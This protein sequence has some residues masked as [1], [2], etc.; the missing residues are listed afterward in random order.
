MLSLS[1][2]FALHWSSPAHLSGF[3]TSTSVGRGIGRWY[4]QGVDKLVFPEEDAWKV[5]IQ[6]SGGTAT[7]P[8]LGGQASWRLFLGLCQQHAFHNRNHRE[9]TCPGKKDAMECFC[10][11]I[12][13]ACQGDQRRRYHRSHQ[14]G[15]RFI[16]FRQNI[17]RWWF[18]L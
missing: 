17:D 5:D 14:R 2:C 16:G 9:A 8:F 12:S 13:A 3:S 6:Q 7:R 18:F 10:M 1:L 15:P 11:V 4:R